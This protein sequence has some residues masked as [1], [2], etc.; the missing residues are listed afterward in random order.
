MTLRDYLNKGSMKASLVM[1][2][3]IVA[4]W[5]YASKQG[6]NSTAKTFAG[7]VGVIAI[8]LSLFIMRCTRRPKCGQGIGYMNGSRRRRVKSLIGLDSCHGC[9]L[10]LDEKIADSGAALCAPA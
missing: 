9:G 1:V 7:I 8:A 10:H 3:L 2:A 4:S 6:W 5:I